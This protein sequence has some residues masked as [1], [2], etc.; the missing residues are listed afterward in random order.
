MV[1]CSHQDPVSFEKPPAS[2]AGCEA[3]LIGFFGIRDPARVVKAEGCSG[4]Q[5]AGSPQ[6]A[7][8]DN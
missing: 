4:G 8:V 3:S 5:L 7:L 1:G 2:I 6:A